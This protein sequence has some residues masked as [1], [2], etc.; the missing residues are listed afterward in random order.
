MANIK[1]ASFIALTKVFKGHICQIKCE[2][3][4]VFVKNP[5]C[6]FSL[7]MLFASPKG[8]FFSMI[9]AS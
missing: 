9:T 7:L 3:N 4:V 1:F 5:F 2:A 8:D 6:V